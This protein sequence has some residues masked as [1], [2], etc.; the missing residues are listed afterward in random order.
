[1]PTAM[2]GAT[3]FSCSLIL[4]TLFVSQVQAGWEMLSPEY[5]ALRDVVRRRDNQGPKIVIDAGHGEISYTLA[6]QYGQIS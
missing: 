6:Q 3:L 4:V 2:G 5:G 1:M